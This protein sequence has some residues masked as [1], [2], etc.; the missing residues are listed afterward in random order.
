MK[1]YLY[2]LGIVLFPF[3]SIAQ[4]LTVGDLIYTFKVSP[5]KAQEYLSQKGFVY[6]NEL[7]E[8]NGGC[9]VSRWISLT[10]GQND[11]IIKSY[12]YS[13]SEEENT[14]VQYIFFNLNHF[15]Q[16]V[17]SINK[18]GYKRVDTWSNID[19]MNNSYQNINENDKI[20]IRLTSHVVGEKSNP[21]FLIKI[22]N[23]ILSLP[24]DN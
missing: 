21:R 7:S 12:C 11:S 13:N 8:S 24:F 5:G 3:I 22:Y 23:K 4:S 14:Y 15:N 18:L 9:P 16:F 1:K 19:G 6:K 2:C 20:E 10:K 17:V